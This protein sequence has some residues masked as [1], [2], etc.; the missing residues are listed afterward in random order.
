MYYPKNKIQANLYTSGGELINSTT[1]KIYIGYYH[2]TFDGKYFSEK[3]NI[4]SSIEL[5]ILSAYKKDLSYSGF[6]YRNNVDVKI[7][8]NQINHDKTLPTKNDYDNG[9]FIRYF[10][11]RVNGGV[12]TIRE[13]NSSDYVNFINDILYITCDIKWKLIGPVYDNKTDPNN[14]ISGVFD[15]NERNVK[16]KEKE[17]SGISK[18]LVNL[19]EYAIIL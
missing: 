9:Y 4:L 1:G 14:F 18:Y 11:K 12:E 19:I 17:M 16:T 2:K 15:T 13:V 3:E 7:P 5:F 8:D 6:I 10:I